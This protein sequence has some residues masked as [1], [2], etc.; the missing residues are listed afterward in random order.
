MKIL[1][2]SLILLLLLSISAYA[3]KIKKIEVT[4]NQRISSE[5]IKVFSGIKVNDEI[6]LEDLNEVI[7]NLYK[8]NYFENV[9]LNINNNILNI[10]VK[11]NP[12]VQSVV[13]DGVKNKVI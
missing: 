3:E 7:K 11:E 9:S 2:K 1:F 8:T 5:T 6:F 4:G 13:I 12:I 10:Q